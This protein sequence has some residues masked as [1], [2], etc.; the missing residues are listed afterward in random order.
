MGPEHTCGPGRSLR[1]RLRLVPVDQ[2]PE[3]HRYFDYQRI[4]NASGMPTEIVIQQNLEANQREYG[5]ETEGPNPVEGL[6][7][8]QRNGSSTRYA[9]AIEEAAS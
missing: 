5:L 4:V 8:P 6:R 9:Q 3:D 7:G 2:L 1:P